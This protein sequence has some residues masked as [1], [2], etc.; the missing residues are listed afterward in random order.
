MKTHQGRR[1]DI[2]IVDFEQINVSWVTS[3]PVIKG[4]HQNPIHY[5]Y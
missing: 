1:S 2:F 4:S 5:F 3:I